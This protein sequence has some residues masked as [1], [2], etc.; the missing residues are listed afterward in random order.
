MTA[1]QLT[2]ANP[3]GN[4]IGFAENTEG[5]TSGQGGQDGHKSG[6]GGQETHVSG[7]GGQIGHMSESG[8]VVPAAL[9]VR[10]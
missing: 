6:A 8:D 2:H 4:L 10:C 1:N 3:A 9:A 7:G 5:G